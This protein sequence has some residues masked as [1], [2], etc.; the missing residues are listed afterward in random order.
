MALR[1]KAI[2]ALAVLASL[3]SFTKFS[4]CEGTTWATPDQYIHACYSDLPSLFSERGLDKNQWPY[5]SN[6][7]AVEYPVLTGMVMFATASLV[8]T[9]IAYFNLNAALLTRGKPAMPVSPCPPQPV[10][11]SPTWYCPRRCSAPFLLRV[12]RRRP[13]IPR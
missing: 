8:N 10:V 12:R 3:L 11:A 2:L 13:L 7:N 1:F 5:A 9:P 4:H 6:T